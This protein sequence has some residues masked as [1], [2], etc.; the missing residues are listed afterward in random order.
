M[1]RSRYMGYSTIEQATDGCWYNDFIMRDTSL[2]SS[3]EVR[4]LVRAGRAAVQLGDYEAARTTFER[5]IALDPDNF[6]AQDGLRDAQ[7]R[8]GIVAREGSDDQVEY[9]YR[10]PETETGLHCV[11]CGRPIC[12]RCSFPA[13]VGQLCPDCRRGRRSPN[14]KLSV[15]SV[16]KGAAIAFVVSTVISLF[17]GMFLRGFFFIFFLFFLAPAIGELV[18]RSVDW[19]TRSKRGQPMQIAVG[20]A[21]IVGAVF[22]VLFGPAVLNLPLIIYLVLAVSTAVARLR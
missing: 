15:G 8:L 3:E 16:V 21:M 22:A 5:A 1:L 10:H 14:Y 9:C 4:G 13:A 12:V 17:I 6:E 7:R 2:D 11:Q 18:I 19:A 20:L